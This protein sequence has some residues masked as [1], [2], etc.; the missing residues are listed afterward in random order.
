M[1]SHINLFHKLRCWLRILCSIWKRFCIL[2]PFN[3]LL[4]I[5]DYG[6]AGWL[7]DPKQH[8]FAIDRISNWVGTTLSW[9]SSFAIS[10]DTRKLS[11][12]ST[13]NVVM[14]SDWM[15]R[16]CVPSDLCGCGLRKEGP[17]GLSV[18]YNN[19]VLLFL[20]FN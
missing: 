2:G 20:F 15:L 8:I 11:R 19:F 6:S 14:T 17:L 10:Q 4:C 12:W 16:K 1:A 9:A 5:V 18:W 3:W 13:S 7:T